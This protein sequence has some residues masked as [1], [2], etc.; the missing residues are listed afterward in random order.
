MV[1]LCG[2]IPVAKPQLIHKFRFYKCCTLADQE[3]VLKKVKVKVIGL[4]ASDVGGQAY[5]Y[6]PPAID[7]VPD[8][9]LM[10]V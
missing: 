10:H 5:M 6:E 9:S 7:N 1:Q 8:S 4:V 2:S 3:E